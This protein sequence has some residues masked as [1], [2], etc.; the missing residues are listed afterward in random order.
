MLIR[1]I[2]TLLRPKRSAPQ[3]SIQEQVYRPTSGWSALNLGEVWRQRELAYYLAW[4]DV[5]VRYKQTVVGIAWAVVQPVTTM[6]VFTVVLGR[7]LG[8]P[9]QGVPYPIFSYAGL[10][11]WSFFAS[12]LPRVGS[13]LVANANLISKVYFPRL[14][15]PI[16]SV[17]ASVLDTAISLV[18]L[19]G[20]MLVYRIV[21]GPAMLS[22][23]FFLLLAMLA[24]LGMGLW[25]CS[26]EVKY[27]DVRHI[28]PFAIQS[29]LLITPVAYPTSLVPERWQLLYKLNPMVGIVEGFRWAILAQNGPPL[30]SIAISTVIVLIVFVSGLFFFRRVEREFAD[31]V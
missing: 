27:R 15:V 23:P 3:Q 2:A 1:H 17:L 9:S 18:V 22:I 14:I 25:L 26:I 6:I 8:V 16:S 20:M 5:K 10:L 29:L 30:D 28:V 11:P 19:L 13:S 24:A 4:R 7:I 31:V 21:P 12:A